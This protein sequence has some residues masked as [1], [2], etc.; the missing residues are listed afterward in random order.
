MCYLGHEGVKL[1]QMIIFTKRS[2]KYLNV[3][4]RLVLTNL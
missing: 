4:L 2:N 1:R 3:V